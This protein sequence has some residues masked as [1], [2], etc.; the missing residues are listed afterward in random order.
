MRGGAK[1]FEPEELASLGSVFDET[2]AAVGRLPQQPRGSGRQD[3]PCQH[4]DRFGPTRL[5][6]AGEIKR[7]AIR[8]S[9]GQGCANRMRR[10]CRLPAMSPGTHSATLASHV[11]ELNRIDTAVLSAVKSGT[12]PPSSKAIFGALTDASFACAEVV[13]SYSAR[14]VPENVRTGPVKLNCAT[15]TR[16]SRAI[17]AAMN[18]APARAASITPR[19]DRHATASAAHEP[20]RKKS[21]ASLRPSWISDPQRL[22]RPSHGAI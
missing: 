18:S 10:Y 12:T 7:T 15:T 4:R 3:A 6:G 9:W 19:A 13:E 21:V 14:A 2:W 1:V 17:Y 22:R 8:V 16:I 11:A 5:V 20:P